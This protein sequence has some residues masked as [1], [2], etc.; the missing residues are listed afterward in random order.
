LV[1]N[2]ASTGSKARHPNINKNPF[3]P[4]PNENSF[5]LGDWHWNHGV[6]KS[7]NSFKGLLDII[8]NPWFRQQ[9]V[10]HTNWNK[11]N[12]KLARNEFDEGDND[13]SWEDVKWMEDDPGWKKTPMKQPGLHNYIAGDLYHRS[14]V[15]VI[16]EKL[17][18]TNNN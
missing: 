3:C 6:Q 12:A 14:I 16:R 13:K 4:Y 8:R 9:D 2:P 10:E 1:D 11:I 15:S 18:N 5:L 17:A 7:H